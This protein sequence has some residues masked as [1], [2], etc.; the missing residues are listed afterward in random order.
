MK[1]LVNENYFDIID[2]ADKA[3]WLGFIWCDGYVGKR[4]RGNYSEYSLK[5]VLSQEDASHLAK[6]LN[7]LG[8]NMEVSHQKLYSGFG[9]S[10]SIYPR[11]LI[12]RKHLASKLYYDYG[13]FPN[14]NDM[15]RILTSIPDE[16][17]KDFLRGAFDADGTIVSR[18]ISYKKSNRKE[19]SIG[20]SSN[21]ELVKLF[22]SVLIQE[23]LTETE[24]KI[25]LRHEGRDGHCRSIRI[26]GNQKVELILDWLYGDS[27]IYLDRKKQR[28]TDMKEYMDAYR[29]EK[30]KV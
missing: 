9:D 5:I 23:G 19:F 22:N 8:S 17:C 13:I 6:F 1:Y 25:G 28:Y 18:D 16:Y 20:I 11:V 29:R 26:T 21:I 15:F 10:G 2:S 3:Y 24:Y 7:C 30:C 27:N 14:R 4:D 12:T